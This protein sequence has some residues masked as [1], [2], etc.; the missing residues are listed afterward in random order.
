VWQIW[1]EEAAELYSEEEEHALFSNVSDMLSH[2][3][4]T[5]VALNYFKRVGLS[6]NWTNVRA[7]VL[8]L[9]Y[10]INVICDIAVMSHS[11]IRTRNMTR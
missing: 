3:N 7:N 5:H 9:I 6:G 2:T 11:L 8:C 10:D 4:K 1:S